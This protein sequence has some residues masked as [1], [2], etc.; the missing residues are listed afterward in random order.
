MNTDLKGRRAIVCGAT[1]GIGRAAAFE[2]AH[3]G[4]AITLLARD[5]AGLKQT[6]ASLPPVDGGSHDYAVADFSRHAEVGQRAHEI[7][8]R[9]GGVHILINNT[10]GPPGGP[11]IDATP[12]AFVDA[13]HAHL[14]CN[15]LLVQA[16]VPGMKDAGY[17]RIINVIST[18]VKEPIPGLG[19]SNTIRGAVASWA[20]TLSNELGPHAI[21]VNNVLPGFT[22]TDRLE[23]IIKTKA[24]KQNRS[25]AEV[26]A[27][28]RRAVPA[29]RFAAPEET[30][31][32]IA[33]LA[34]PAAGYINGVSL[35]VDGGRIASI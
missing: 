33:F 23:S 29:G 12:Q 32:A 17:G 5:D 34:S 1:R 20:K 14:I 30:A 28:M 9:H 11:L 7:A 2:L 19:V 25:E 24:G 3:L 6:C 16:V 27:E 31:A 4:A 26:A 21:T 15:H 35:P 18:S 10:G 13:F 8:E 22:S